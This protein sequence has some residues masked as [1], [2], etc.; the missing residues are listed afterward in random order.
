MTVPTPD[1]HAEEG[2]KPSCVIENSSGVDAS[3]GQL[4][5]CDE[6]KV[7][8]GAHESLLATLKPACYIAII[9]FVHQSVKT[10]MRSKYFTLQIDVFVAL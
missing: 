3:L 9:G 10:L 8:E 4:V 2:S 1:I 6:P 7:P 5:T